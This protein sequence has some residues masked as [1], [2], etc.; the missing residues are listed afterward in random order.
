[1]ESLKSRGFILWEP[2]F[3]EQMPWKT[4]HWFLIAY[5]VE[6]EFSNYNYGI[7]CLH[8]EI[9]AKVTHMGSL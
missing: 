1:M 9:V 3:A 8:V 4:C 6:T 7:S 5:K 2:E